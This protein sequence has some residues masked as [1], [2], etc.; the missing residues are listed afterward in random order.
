MLKMVDEQSRIPEV[1]TK[2]SNKE[3][4]IEGKPQE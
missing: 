3:F 1:G 4:W 2:I